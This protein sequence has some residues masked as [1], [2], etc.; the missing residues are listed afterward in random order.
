MQLGVGREGNRRAGN[1]GISV[2]IYSHGESSWG[3]KEFTEGA[4]TI[5][6]GSIFHFFK[7]PVEKD[8]FLRRRRQ[9][10]CRTLKG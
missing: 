1:Y 10:P 5:G 6:A 9:G 8:D 3:L 7:T 2:N 4:V